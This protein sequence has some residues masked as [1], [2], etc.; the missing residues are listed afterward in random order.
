MFEG[1]G[2]DVKTCHWHPF[3]SL[4]VTGSK[5]CYVKI[6][7]PKSGKEINSIH[8]H[9][10]TINQVRWNPLNGNWL[11][12]GSRDHSLKIF[13]IRTMKEFNV[14]QKHSDQVTAIAWHPFKEELF[15]SAS[16]NG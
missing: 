5:D 11:L 6:W 14:F 10:N 2:S 7:D 3:Q 4:V 13:D 12:I 1:H 8:S 15:A 9:N 16:H